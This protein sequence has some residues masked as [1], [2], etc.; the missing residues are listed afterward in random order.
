MGRMDGASNRPVEGCARHRRVDGRDVWQRASGS[1]PCRKG[2]GPRA[3][4]SVI[5]TQS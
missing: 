4:L 3:A 5:G 1:V 2:A